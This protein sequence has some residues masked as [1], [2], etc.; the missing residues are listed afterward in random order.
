M[1]GFVNKVAEFEN[2]PF[3]NWKP[4]ETLQTR[5]YVLT[6]WDSEHQSSCCILH[7]LQFHNLTDCES[8]VQRVKRIQFRCDQ[9]MNQSLKCISVQEFPDAVD[10]VKLMESTL[11]H[12]PDRCLSMLIVSS[13]IT[14]MFLADTAGDTWHLPIASG[15]GT[16]L[17]WA[18]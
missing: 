12:L 5:S 2:D 8:T 14:P 15:A 1:L 13:K 4:M 11:A 7:P 3:F 9:S 10:I 6:S 17:R 16:L 18:D